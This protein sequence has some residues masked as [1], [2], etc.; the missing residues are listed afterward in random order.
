MHHIVLTPEDERDLRFH[1]HHGV[2]AQARTRCL[3]ILMRGNGLPKVAIEKLTGAALSSQTYWE[4]AWKQGG[5]RAL[6]ESGHKGRQSSLTPSELES[7][8][9]QFA[10]RPPAT[11]AEGRERV[12]VA[13]GRTFSLASAGDLLRDKLKLRRRKAKQVPPRCDD[14]KKN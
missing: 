9:R 1:S 12:R 7:L 14:P 10:A 5:L 8:G 4:R 3:A 2:S 6:V 13:T 11:L